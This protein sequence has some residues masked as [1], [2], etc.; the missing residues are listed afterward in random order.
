[1]LI[2]GWEPIITNLCHQ[3]VR[4]VQTLLERS[5]IYSAP[6]EWNKLSEYIR[7]SNFDSF[8][9]SDKIMLF[10]QQYGCLVKIIYILL[11]LWSLLIIVNGSYCY[12]V[13]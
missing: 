5:C 8:M 1:M 7:T 12:I 13:H 10:T 2:R 9:K 6:C 3:F 11:I 4:I